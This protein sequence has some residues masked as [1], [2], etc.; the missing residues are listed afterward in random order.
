MF[1]GRSTGLGGVFASRT[2]YGCHL[3]PGAPHGPVQARRSD[4][5]LR[6]DQPRRL[7]GSAQGFEGRVDRGGLASCH[8]RFGGSNTA[9][10][11]PWPPPV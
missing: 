8:L 4:A 7:A 11:M 6:R 2:A 3:H 5:V 9:S 1:H 10:V